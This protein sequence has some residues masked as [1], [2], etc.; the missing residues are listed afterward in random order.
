M[1]NRLNIGLLIVVCLVIFAL[2]YSFYF[3]LDRI[4]SDSAPIKVNPVH[5]HNQSFYSYSSSQSSL[6]DKSKH[7]LPLTEDVRS[8]IRNAFKIINPWMESR[9]SYKE[10]SLTVYSGYSDAVLETLM[11]NGDLKA[12]TL[13]SKRVCKEADLSQIEAIRSNP[14]WK[15][16]EDSIECRKILNETILMGSIESPSR[17]AAIY[18]YQ[19]L[20]VYKKGNLE[21]IRQVAI[22]QN[23]WN[24]LRTMISGDPIG[25]ITYEIAFPHAYL[26][27][28]EGQEA[29]HQRASEL[30]YQLQ[31]ERMQRGW[32]PFD[33]SY[34]VKEFALLEKIQAEY[35]D[36]NNPNERINFED[37]AKEF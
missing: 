9:G 16:I 30:F 4:E 25:K 12:A 14:N 17:L 2:L 32:G 23:A 1:L 3:N 31:E 20:P 21:E 34:P 29:I 37:F 18:G 36:T 33:T 5:S 7:R 10:Q 15:W 35:Y 13:L 24:K 28:P 8:Q 27:N 26:R 11:E 6:E 19:Y 22:E